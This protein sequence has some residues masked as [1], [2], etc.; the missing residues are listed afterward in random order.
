MSR[1]EDCIVSCGEG[2]CITNLDIRRSWV[3]S[4]QTFYGKAN[5]YYRVYMSQ[6]FV[7]RIPSH[8]NP[9]QAIIFNFFTMHFNII[10]QL[11]PKSSKRSRS[12]RFTNKRL[13]KQVHFPTCATS[14]PPW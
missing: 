2:R 11:N 5:M 4:F 12:L 14:H 13:Q 8:I 3:T 6:P 1:Y 10:L 9:V 7:L